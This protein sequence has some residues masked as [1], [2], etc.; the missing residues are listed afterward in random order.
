MKT[1]LAKSYAVVTLFLLAITCYANNQI[2]WFAPS[3]SNLRG[4]SGSTCSGT[5]STSYVQARLH[6]VGFDITAPS[7][8]AGNQ[9]TPSSKSGIT[10]G[11]YTLQVW[12]T[13]GTVVD[14]YSF[15]M[16]TTNNSSDT[17]ISVPD[18]CNGESITNCAVVT[19]RNDDIVPRDYWIQKSCQ[20]VCNSLYTVMPG[21]SQS[22]LIYADAGDTSGWTVKR[23]KAGYGWTYHGTSGCV[24]A[25]PTTAG[26][27]QQAL[28]TGAEDDVGPVPNWGPSSAPGNN[29]I[30]DSAGVSQGTNPGTNGP[31]NFTN[32]AGTDAILKTGF[33]ALYDAIVKTGQENVEAVQG[34]GPKIDNVGGVVGSLSNSIGSRIGEVVTAINGQGGAASN[35]LSQLLANGTGTNIINFSGTNIAEGGVSNAV[36]QFHRDSTNWFQGIVSA[37]TNN[38]NT[39]EISGLGTNADFAVA[40]MES[41]FNDSLAELDGIAEG[42]SPD[43]SG[44]L[45]GSAPGPWE[46]NMPGGATVVFDP[47]NDY[48]PVCN[49][50]FNVLS[51]L[52]VVGYLAKILNESRVLM[53]QIG[54]VETTKIPNLQF[55]VFGSGGN[56]AGVAMW[57]LLAT[58]FCVLAGILIAALI[59]WITGTAMPLISTVSL[60]NPFGS[61]VGSTIISSICYVIPV[62]LIVS[63]AVSYLAWQIVMAKLVIAF[64]MAARW[65]VG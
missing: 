34:L 8:S 37:I 32:S 3:G 38:S 42:F 28:C 5:P 63:L 52:A 14:V 15:Y 51:W 25:T 24:T 59:T 46:L 13:N 36:V 54:K 50:M 9:S 60:S 18:L 33:N 35:L 4:S 40:Q 49:L 39:N 56:P 29:P 48:A 6:R 58:A 17:L 12:F 31:V 41:M 64:V 2:I 43:T 22:W 21:Q 30:V 27:V 7:V 47:F 26:G 44:Y 1:N 62:A 57:P 10:A 53:T 45:R 20:M 11:T 55:S 23:L 65:I 19:V 16:A 61:G